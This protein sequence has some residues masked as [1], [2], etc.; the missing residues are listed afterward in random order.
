MNKEEKYFWD[1]FK[2]WTIDDI[3]I[4]FK[5]K[6]NVATAKLICCAIDAFGSFY[7][8]RGFRGRESL[9]RP[10]GGS[11]SSNPEKKGSRD[12][13]VAFSSNYIY[14]AKNLVIKVGGKKKNGTEFLYDNF[15]NGLIHGGVPSGGVGIVRTKSKKIFV[16]ISAQGILINLRPFKT[17]LK[18]A[19]RSYDKDLKDLNQPERLK[20]WRDRYRYLKLFNLRHFK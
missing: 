2:R 15:R 3:D 7:I 19:I 1:S 18:Q 4:C 20:R 5:Y 10:G 14:E 6:A 17:S 11:G 12:A 16:G 9:V 8:G 13:F